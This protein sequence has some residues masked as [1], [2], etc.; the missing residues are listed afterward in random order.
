L[1]IAANNVGLTPVN[2]AA[3]PSV[4]YMAKIVL[5]V[6]LDDDDDDSFVHILLFGKEA[7]ARIFT[8]SSGL[9]A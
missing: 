5:N 6:P 8:T 4:L 9:N 2:S 3:L 7:W 1:G